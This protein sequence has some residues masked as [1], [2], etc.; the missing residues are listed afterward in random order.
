[1]KLFKQTSAVLSPVATDASD[2]VMI[3]PAG[4]VKGRDGR[5]PYVL[6]EMDKVVAAS[7]RDSVELF[8]DR[9]HVADIAAAG[10]AAPAAGWIKGMEPRED[11]IYALIEWTAA[12]AA[13][14]RD[15]EYRYLSPTFWHDTAGRITRIDRVS[16]VNDPNFEMRAIAAQETSTET[17]LENQM[18]ELLKELAALLGLEGE[19]V[20][21]EAVKEAVTNLV[22]VKDAVKEEVAAPAEAETAEEIVAAVEAAVDDKVEKEVASR[23][24]K[25]TASQ[26]NPDPSKFV[27]IEALEEMKKSVA[28]VQSQ[29]HA[30]DTEEVVEAALAAGKI[31][32]AQK[33][34]AKDYASSD[35]K[36]FKQYLEKTPAI[37]TPDNLP[38]FDKAAGTGG[39]LSAVEKSV[40]SQLGLSEEQF[41]SNGKKQA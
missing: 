34:W 8:V 13:Q 19:S 31:L 7:L 32:P 38:A 21:P 41:R 11:G 35:L 15:K 27:P 4:I 6:D 25:A 10:T 26:K 17:E 18:D 37:F 14:L 33:G 29:L 23:L 5:G 1:M 2:W 28:S 39:G 24:K 30:R 20:S 36:G 22:A 16:L 12:A 9:D 3:F 40:A